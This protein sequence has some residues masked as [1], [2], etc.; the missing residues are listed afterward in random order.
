MVVL[1]PGAGCK[2][3]TGVQ[4]RPRGGH[5]RQ[6]RHGRHGDRGRQRGAQL[7]AGQRQHRGQR[8]PLRAGQV[9]YEGVNEISRN[10]I[11]TYIHYYKWA[12]KH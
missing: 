12:L 10:T 9:D 4:E 7:I 5:R 1:M 11:F 2:H 3:F 8:L 6:P